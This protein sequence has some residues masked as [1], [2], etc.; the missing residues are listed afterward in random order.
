LWQIEGVTNYI[1]MI[2]SGHVAVYLYKWKNLYQYLQQ[3]W[4]AINSLIKTFFFR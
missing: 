3:G 4:E 2:G 1:H